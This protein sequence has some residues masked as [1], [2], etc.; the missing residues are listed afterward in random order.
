MLF[1]TP[2]SLCCR[3]P[4]C[5]Q[6]SLAPQLRVARPALSVGSRDPRQLNRNRESRQPLV[7]DE[8]LQGA[9]GRVL[10]LVGRAGR[11]AAGY[12]HSRG[13]G[14]DEDYDAS[15]FNHMKY[16]SFAE[17][18]Q[19]VEQYGSSIDPR[20]LVPMF[21][22]LKG[23]PGGSRQQKLSLLH[24]LLQLL[25]PH[26]QKVG[27]KGL[28]EVLLTC[29]RLGCFPAAFHSSVLGVLCCK[30]EEAETRTISKAIYAV[31][32]APDSNTQHQCWP[33]IEQLL[34][35]AFLRLSNNAD[36]FDLSNIVWSVGAMRQRLPA[37]S[38]QLLIAELLARSDRVRPRYVS[39]VIIGVAKQ[40][41]WIPPEQLA[42]LLLCVMEKLDEGKPRD[43][44]N[45]IYAMA[46]TSQPVSAATLKQLVAGF[47]SKLPAAVPQDMSTTLWAATTTGQPLHPQQLLQLLLPF[48]DK[49]TDDV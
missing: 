33:F 10:R 26:L 11:G 14:D 7:P 17:L 35:P 20:Y 24:L 12:R 2:A 45:V 34:L 46:K 25:W 36:A 42:P 31:A 9:A 40:G 48:A 16:K 38:V 22:R 19:L 30:I 44:F 8:E 47:I 21:T 39:K 49:L 1:C 29:S 43:I 5:S 4:A 3:Q 18:I 32:T 15:R 6:R 28:S 41:Q 27:P 13:R 23:V 37:A